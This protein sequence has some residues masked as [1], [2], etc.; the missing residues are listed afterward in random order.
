MEIH[1]DTKRGEKG[2][3]LSIAAYLCLSAFKLVVGYMTN[4]EALKADGW[5]NTTDIFAS[6]AVLIG[7]I[8]SRKPADHDH[9]YGH[10]R[11][12]TIAALIASFIMVSV[13]L[14]VLY[15]AIRSLFAAS[16]TVPNLMA[17]GTAGISAG[18]MYA[19]YRYNK[20]LAEKTQSGALNAAAQDNRSDALV[21]V[22]AL[23]G[24][25][26]AQFGVHWLDPLA[27]VLVGGIICKTAWDI[28]KDASNALTDGFDYDKL[29][30]FRR[31]VEL[32]PGVHSVK[33]IRARAHG[34]NILVD[35][36]I[37]VNRKLTVVE[38]HDI[39]ENIESRMMDE[40]QIEHVHIHV[41]PSKGRT[42]ELRSPD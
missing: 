38:S 1:S 13:G 4:S 15:G 12:E 34:N 36:V 28:F 19:V 7:L 16:P 6:T 9:R 40:H 32:T 25:M 2:V 42:S 39:S 10:F 27:A 5:N 20:H 22:G 30:R 35:V 11:A 37:E 24:I 8:I 33:D 17:A 29:R 3:W 31:T 23:V 26:G 41:E 14:Q 18:I 21:S